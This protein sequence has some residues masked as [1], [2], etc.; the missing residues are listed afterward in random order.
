MPTTVW[1]RSASLTHLRET[2]ARDARSAWLQPSAWRRARIALP[3]SRMDR[4]FMVVC[5]QM[6]LFGY[7][8]ML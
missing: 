2:P 5:P 4:I 7:I 1:P 6:T 3:M 8:L